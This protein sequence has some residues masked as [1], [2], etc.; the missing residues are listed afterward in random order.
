MKS[1]SLT[2]AL[3]LVASSLVM[4]QTEASGP[5]HSREVHAVIQRVDH[6]SR[7]VLLSYETEQGPKGV[8]WTPNTRFVHDS[9][10]ASDEELKDGSHATVRYRTPFF[11]KPIAT[12]IEWVTKSARE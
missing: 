12:S 10:P 11:G 8:T 9:K 3:A 6:E 7:T 2:L 5:M 4:C 1:A